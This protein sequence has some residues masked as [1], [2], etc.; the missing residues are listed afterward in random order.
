MNSPNRFVIQNPV[1]LRRTG[2][3]NPDQTNQKLYGQISPDLALSL[4]GRGLG[5]GDRIR[6]A[7]ILSPSP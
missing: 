4:Y 5:E 2:R 1:R 6:I 3:K 7:T